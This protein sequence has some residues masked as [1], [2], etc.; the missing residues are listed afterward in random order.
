MS[1]N[2]VDSTRI[3]DNPDSPEMSENYFADFTFELCNSWRCV[4]VGIHA[5]PMMQYSLVLRGI[6]EY[7]VDAQQYAISPGNGFFVNYNRFHLASPSSSEVEFLS[8]LVRPDFVSGRAGG[9][10]AMKFS[11]PY[12]SSKSSNCL[13]LHSA[14][15]IAK[16]VLDAMLE[17]W[18]SLRYKNFGYELSIK[19]LAAQVWLNTVLLLRNNN[20]KSDTPELSMDKIRIDQIITYIHLYYSKKVTLRELAEC[21]NISEGECC[22]LFKRVLGA[23]PIEF[24]N[25]FRI[26]QAQLLLCNTHSSILQIAQDSG[27]P[28]INH[29][30]AMFKRFCGCTPR[31]FRKKIQ[32]SPEN[33]QKEM[34]TVMQI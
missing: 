4:G 34:N 30:I 8:F 21:A 32:L 17:I 14:D 19:S 29:F 25:R 33:V 1:Y 7:T 10:T 12:I 6:L 28:S 13:M 11:D 31:E 22:R 18:D 24:L 2:P 3:I 26:S 5:H 20:Y 15:P 27:F 16:K 23:T 9:S